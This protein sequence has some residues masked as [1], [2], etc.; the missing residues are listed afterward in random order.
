MFAKQTLSRRLLYTVF[1]WYLLIAL[2]MTMAELVIQYVSVSR[3]I[4]SDLN[5]LSQMVAPSVTNAVWELDNQ[6]LQSIAHGVRKNAIITGLQIESA[7]GEVLIVDGE[8]PAMSED[9]T[10]SFL[11]RFKQ[12]VL[13]LSYQSPRGE[14]FLIG[15]LKMYSNRQVVLA[16]QSHESYTRPSSSAR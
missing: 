5:S 10:D 7:T 8:I 15:H 4:D 16:G 3:N 6:Q 12:S 13:P 11:S 14:S 9:V 1:P 2:I